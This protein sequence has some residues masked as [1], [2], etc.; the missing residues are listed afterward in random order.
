MNQ[1][2]RKSGTCSHAAVQ[3]L[4][5]EIIAGRAAALFPVDVERLT[6]RSYFILNDCLAQTIWIIGGHRDDGKRLVVRG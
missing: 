1:E 3:R 6:L 2:R 5:P 4:H